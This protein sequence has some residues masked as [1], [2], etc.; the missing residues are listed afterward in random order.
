MRQVVTD[1]GFD[2]SE[3]GFDGNSCG[4]LVAIARQSPDIAQ[5][6]NRALEYRINGS[7]EA[8]LEATGAGD[9]GMMF[10]FACNETE[11]F[12]PLPIHLAHGLTQRLSQVR[13]DGTLPWVCPV[14]PLPLVLTR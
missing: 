2:S 3:K 14:L 4:V 8:E 1:I 12:M 7:E 13:R 11:V 5:G 10:G 6:V 9:Q